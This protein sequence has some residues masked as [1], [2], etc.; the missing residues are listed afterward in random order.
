VLAALDMEKR[1]IT[2]DFRTCV[3]EAKKHAKIEIG[4][5]LL[6]TIK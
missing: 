3:P 4:S 2:C 1:F 6:E 5:Q